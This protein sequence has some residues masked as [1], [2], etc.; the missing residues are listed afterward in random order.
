M[1][2]DAI[3]CVN[4]AILRM[5]DGLQVTDFENLTDGL[6]HLNSRCEP[7]GMFPTARVLITGY[8]MGI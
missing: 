2:A 7:P 8:G 5:E 1:E 3:D 4:L 6:P